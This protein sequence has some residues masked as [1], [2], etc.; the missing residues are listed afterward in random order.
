M[1]VYQDGIY[2]FSGAN[3]SGKTTT[4]R[5]LLGILTPDGGKIEVLGVDPLLKV[6]QLRQRVN[7]LPGSYL[8]KLPHRVCCKSCITLVVSQ[9]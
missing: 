7:A 3:G 2:G 5:I 6:N 9:T 4:L 8:L 1:T